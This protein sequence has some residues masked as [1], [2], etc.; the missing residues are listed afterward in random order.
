METAYNKI[1]RKYVPCGIYHNE[2]F[3]N[4][5]LWLIQQN[6]KSLTSMMW[7]VGELK[8]PANVVNHASLQTLALE[9]AKYI[10][11]IQEEGSSS[12]VDLMKNFR[13]SGSPKVLG[14]SNWDLA[15]AIL[16]HIAVLVEQKKKPS[17][18]NKLDKVTPF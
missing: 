8:D 11:E 2:E 3:L 17:N 18:K 13:T 9:L 4:N 5:G 14:I 10:G 1:G 12:N 15:H 6:G 16:R 7:L